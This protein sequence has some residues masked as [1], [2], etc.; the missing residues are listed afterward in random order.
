MIKLLSCAGPEGIPLERRHVYAV[1]T[2]TAMRQGELR[3]LRVN[4]IDFD[5]MQITVA[6]QVKNGKEKDRTKTG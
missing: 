6:R 2:Y 4:D 5:A 1:A 3:A